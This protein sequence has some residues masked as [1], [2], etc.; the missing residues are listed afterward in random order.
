V[1]ADEAA[2]IENAQDR[3]SRRI[4]KEK[5]DGEERPQ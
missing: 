2:R 5:H 4:Y 3:Q 1:T